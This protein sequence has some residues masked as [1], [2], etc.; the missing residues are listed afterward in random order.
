MYFAVNMSL[1][2]RFSVQITA[3]YL[4]A[5]MEDQQQWIEAIAR[6]GRARD[7]A[8]AAIYQ[9]A[10]LRRAV[11]ATIRKLSGHIQDCEDMYQESLIIMDRNIREGRYE[12][13]GTLAA[14]LCGIARFCWLNQRRKQERTHLVEEP[15]YDVAQDQVPGP[16]HWVMDR[17]KEALLNQ[18]LEQL[19]ERCHAHSPALAGTHFHAGDR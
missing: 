4:T 15:R 6:G 3:C 14:Y 19:D 9:D 16:D 8:L 17:E 18:F 2:S 12:D 1:A 10:G 11:F 5:R 7:Q 13:Q